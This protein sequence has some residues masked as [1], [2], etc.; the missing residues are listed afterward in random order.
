LLLWCLWIL[1]CVLDLVVVDD[2]AVVGYSITWNHGDLP[3][4][5]RRVGGPPDCGEGG[6]GGEESEG[7]RTCRVEP[8]FHQSIPIK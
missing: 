4:P 1:D 5:K 8:G 7:C 3:P 6:G 2:V